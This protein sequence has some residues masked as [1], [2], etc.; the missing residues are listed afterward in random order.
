MD[1]ATPTSGTALDLD[2]IE[3]WNVFKRL[4][5]LSIPC[6]CAC[7]QPLQVNIETATAAI[8]VWSVVQQFTAPRNVSIKHLERCWKQKVK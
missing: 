3:R 4:K 1:A 7:G 8:Q 2:R 5:E 6:Q